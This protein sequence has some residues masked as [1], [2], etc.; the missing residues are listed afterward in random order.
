[1]CVCVG[2][3]HWGSVSVCSDPE[4]KDSRTAVKRIIPVNLVKN[5][6]WKSLFYY[7][8]TGEPAWFIH[9]KLWR[10]SRSCFSTLNLPSYAGE[11]S[12]MVIPQHC[13]RPFPSTVANV[14]QEAEFGAFSSL[15][16][17]VKGVFNYILPRSKVLL[18]WMWTS[19]RGSHFA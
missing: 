16:N 1:M 9:I 8:K 10:G 6:T 5:H 13:V 7:I 17:T 3:G 2:G 11:T 18:M 19:V 14:I 4:H 15:V 12:L